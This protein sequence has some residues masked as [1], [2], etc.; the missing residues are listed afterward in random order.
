[1]IQIKGILLSGSLTKQ[2]DSALSEKRK[3][4]TNLNI[5]VLRLFRIGVLTS[6]HILLLVAEAGHRI[7]D[8]ITQQIGFYDFL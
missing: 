2:Q 5:E 6:G 1:M 8:L 4:P 3:L 7:E